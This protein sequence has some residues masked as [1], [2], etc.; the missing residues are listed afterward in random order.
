MRGICG[1]DAIRAKVEIS[2]DG[3]FRMSARLDQGE[4][5]SI[6]VYRTEGYVRGSAERLSFEG[7]G[8]GVLSEAGL[9]VTLGPWPVSSCMGVALEP[10]P[11]G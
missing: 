1:M 2:A 5:T 9:A 11:E 7:V 10:A 8:S 6:A 4:R 3:T